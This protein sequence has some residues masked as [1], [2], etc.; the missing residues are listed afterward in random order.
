MATT[1]TGSGKYEPDDIRFQTFATTAPYRWA[2]E[3]VRVLDL[4]P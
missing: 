3:P 1:R 4:T 2:A